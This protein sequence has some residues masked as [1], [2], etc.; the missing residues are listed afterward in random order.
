MKTQDSLEVTTSKSSCQEKE[1]DFLRH[2]E[3]NTLTAGRTYLTESE[4]SSGRS[5][6]LHLEPEIDKCGCTWEGIVLIFKE[7]LK[8]N[9][10]LKQREHQGPVSFIP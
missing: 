7:L 9:D 8:I 4:S 2:A 10:C 5:T 3:L 6:G 1:D